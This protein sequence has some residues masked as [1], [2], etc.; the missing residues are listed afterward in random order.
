MPGFWNLAEGQ[1]PKSLKLIVEYSSKPSD[2]ER[3]EASEAQD[4]TQLS[5]QYAKK[6]TSKLL[7]YF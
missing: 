4:V 7:H 3:S 1:I 2:A 6:E 5:E